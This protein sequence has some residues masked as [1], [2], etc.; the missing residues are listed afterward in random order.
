MQ[1]T[2]ATAMGTEPVA[3]ISEVGSVWAIIDGFQDQTHDFLHYLVSYGWDSELS[4]LAIGFRDKDG[5]DWL[6]VKLLGLH[7]FD[8]LSNHGERNPINRA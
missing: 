7:L 8:D 4:H 6:K 2:M 5:P 3:G 1:S